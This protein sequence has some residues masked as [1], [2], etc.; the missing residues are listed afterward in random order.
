M[1]AFAVACIAAVSLSAPPAFAEGSYFG[2]GV[3]SAKLDDRNIDV[4]THSSQITGVGTVTPGGK[5]TAVSIR[6]GSRF[7]RYAAL[8]LG[9][10]DFG[11]YDFDQVVPTDSS[12]GVALLRGTSKARAAGAS[13]IGIV[14]IDRVELYGRVGYARS[15]LKTAG[16]AGDVRSTNTL[17]EN[18]VFSGAGLRWYVTDKI[19]VYVE[20]LDFDKLGL[21][22]GMLG[23]DL[24]F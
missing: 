4:E 22:T 17:K 19:G 2:L 24:S 20:Y 15:E 10:Y 12:G 9:Y 21:K 14:H 6:F 7:H 13:L 11:K 18:G 1:K 8:E 5:D 16:S 23:V 3:G